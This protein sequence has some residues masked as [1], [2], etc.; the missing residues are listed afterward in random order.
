MALLGS[1]LL[2]LQLLV[3]VL[4]KLNIEY[5]HEWHSWKSEHEVSYQDEHEELGRH[6]VWLSNKKYIE[7]HNKYSDHFGYALEMNKFG[8]MVN[9]LLK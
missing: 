8:D 6:V 9:N 1:L 3:L 4:A 5:P 2:V 7:E